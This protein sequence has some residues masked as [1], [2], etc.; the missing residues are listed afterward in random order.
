MGMPNIVK[1][2]KEAVVKETGLD[3]P[4]V[5]NIKVSKGL[6]HVILDVFDRSVKNAARTSRTYD[7]KVDEAG[8][9]KGYTPVP[10]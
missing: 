7:V 9:L 5:I 3:Y 6:Y 2:A 10:K 8:R 1:I 4:R